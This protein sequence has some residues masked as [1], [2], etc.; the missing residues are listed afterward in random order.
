MPQRSYHCTLQQPGEGK[1]TAASGYGRGQSQQPE[2][3]TF[4]RRVI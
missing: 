1:E 2:I 3:S 4:R